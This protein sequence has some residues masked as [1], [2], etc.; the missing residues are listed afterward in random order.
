MAVNT[1]HDHTKSAPETL[2]EFI[3]AAPKGTW[4]A[5]YEGLSP[6]YPQ[7]NQERHEEVAKLIR[8]YVAEGRLVGTLVCTDPGTNDRRGTYRYFAKVLGKPKA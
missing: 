1:Y 8:R 2:I 3:C 4:L 7:P 6:S 5:Y